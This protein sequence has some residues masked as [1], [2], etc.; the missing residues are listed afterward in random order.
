MDKT[1]T[2][3]LVINMEIPQKYF[4]YIIRLQLLNKAIR[5]CA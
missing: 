4:E 5:R 2:A 1:I 3:S